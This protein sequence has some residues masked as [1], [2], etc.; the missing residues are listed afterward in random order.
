MI[1][2]AQKTGNESFLEKLNENLFSLVSVG[3]LPEA[4][5]HM[6][7]NLLPPAWNSSLGALYMCPQKVLKLFVL[8]VSSDTLRKAFGSQWAKSQHFSLLCI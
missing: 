2:T 1:T 4:I 8:S 7:F 3:K 6:G 5:M